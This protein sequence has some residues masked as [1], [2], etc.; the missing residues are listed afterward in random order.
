MVY[1]RPPFH[2]MS[3]VIKIR[4]IPNPNHEIVYPEYTSP[5]ILGNMETPDQ[6]RE[7]ERTKVPIDIINSI[8]LCLVRDPKKRATIPQLLAQAWITGGKAYIALL[9]VRRTDYDVKSQCPT[10]CRSPKPLLPTN[11]CSKKMNP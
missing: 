10:L 8:R 1:G 9:H 6:P 7:D 5:L 11:L 4:E 2:A 3:A